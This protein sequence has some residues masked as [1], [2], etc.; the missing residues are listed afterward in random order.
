MPDHEFFFAKTP[1]T[2]KMPYIERN[3]AVELS[4]ATSEL[5]VA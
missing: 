5:A 3:I 4:L 2:F 1:A